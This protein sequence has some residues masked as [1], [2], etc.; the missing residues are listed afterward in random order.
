MCLRAQGID[1][2]D[3]GVVRVRRARG[4][5]DYYGGVGRGRGIDDASEGLDTTTEAAGDRQR[6]QGIYDD[7][8][9]VG[10]GR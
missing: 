8:G 9:D 2:D 10:G 5:R 7:G 3:D 6:A 4:L 1:D